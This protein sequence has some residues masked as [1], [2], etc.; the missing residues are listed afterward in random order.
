M[1]GSFGSDSEIQ[2]LKTF[3]H[4][5]ER[6]EKEARR[7]ITDN[8]EDDDCELYLVPLIFDELAVDAYEVSWL[9]PPVAKIT[10]LN[11]LFR[12]REPPYQGAQGLG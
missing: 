3:L 10:A 5:A 1:S 7:F 11:E 6:T 2:A 8:F 12:L 9:S 4:S